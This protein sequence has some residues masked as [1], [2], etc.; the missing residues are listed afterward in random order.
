[1]TVSQILETLPL[2]MLRQAQHERININDMLHNQSPFA[3]S[4]EPVERS[5][6]DKD[7]LRE[8]QT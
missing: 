4:R 6:G 3:L 1:M 7:F 5:K 2:F 8:H